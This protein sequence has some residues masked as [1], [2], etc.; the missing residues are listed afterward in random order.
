[1]E[2]HRAHNAEVVGSNP[3]P[4]TN[5]KKERQMKKKYA[6]V[7][8]KAQIVV[9]RDFWVRMQEIEDGFYKEIFE[10]EKEMAKVSK[11]KDIEFFRSPD[12]GCY[13]GI[14][15]DS[16]TMELIQRDELDK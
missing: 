2:A 11:I 6:V 1:M 10:L 13:C 7:P 15:N 12:D 14:G 3:T 4:A 16:R 9:M 8:T 5:K